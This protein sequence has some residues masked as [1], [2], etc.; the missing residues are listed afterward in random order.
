MREELECEEKRV[1]DLPAVTPLKDWCALVTVV[2]DT[3]IARA[4]PFW[5][6]MALWVHFPSSAGVEGVADVSEFTSHSAPQPSS[7]VC[8]GSHKG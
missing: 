6:Q 7:L 1:L 5:S 4:A 8:C 2:M 3:H